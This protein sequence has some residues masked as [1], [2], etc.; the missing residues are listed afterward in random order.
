MLEVESMAHSLDERACP[1]IVH[2]M[3][4]LMDE[5]EQAQGEGLPPDSAA[6]KCRL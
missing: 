6:M 5:A 1:Q 3:V 2:A 4:D